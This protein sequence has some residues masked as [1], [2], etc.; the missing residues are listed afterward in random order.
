MAVRTTGAEADTLAG[1][2]R[3]LVTTTPPEYV[4]AR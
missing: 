2:Q 3:A 4:P 1:M